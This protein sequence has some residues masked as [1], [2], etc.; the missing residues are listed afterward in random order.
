MTAA[1]EWYRIY[2]GKDLDQAIKAKG[3][4]RGLLSTFGNVDMSI[5]KDYD[6]YVTNFVTKVTALAK[7]T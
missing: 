1:T 2:L 4:L 6:A 5:K 3:Q 7:K